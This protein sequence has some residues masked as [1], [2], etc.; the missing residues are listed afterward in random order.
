MKGEM[1]KRKED[2]LDIELMDTLQKPVATKVTEM[3]IKTS[4]ALG[5]GLGHNNGFT[6]DNRKSKVNQADARLRVFKAY[7]Q[8]KI[9]LY[10]P[11]AV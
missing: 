3:E 5:F 11:Y 1:K 8:Q 4:K 2:V 7:V 10:R 6:K 9:K